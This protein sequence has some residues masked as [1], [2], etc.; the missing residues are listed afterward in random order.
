MQPERR[1]PMKRA[2]IYVRVSTEDQADNYSIASQK[3]ACQK[4]AEEHGFT[5]IAVCEDVMTGSTLDRPQ[6][7]EARSL[8]RQGAADILIVYTLDRLTRSVAHALLLRDE[9]R[10]MG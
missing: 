3:A 5:V 9:V 10:S 6:L 7:T 1:E 8:I 4:Y 2:I